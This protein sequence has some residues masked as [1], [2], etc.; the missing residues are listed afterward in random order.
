[1]NT[2]PTPFNQ[3]LLHQEYNQPG[4]AYPRHYTYNSL[5]DACGRVYRKGEL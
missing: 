1:M 5:L 2:M 4:P 3:G